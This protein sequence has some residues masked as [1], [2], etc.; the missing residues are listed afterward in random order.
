[1]ELVWDNHFKKSYKKRIADNPIIKKKFIEKIKLFSENPY[2]PTLETHK[3]KGKLKE[4]SAFSIDDNIRV[5][6]KQVEKNVYM[7][8]DIGTH[9]DVY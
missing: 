3:L 6:F 5:I 1:M 7:L 9:D 8:I 2:N 4:L